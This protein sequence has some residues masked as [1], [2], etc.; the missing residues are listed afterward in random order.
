VTY[1]RFAK[2][3]NYI[4]QRFRAV[5]PEG[6]PAFAGVYCNKVVARVWYSIRRL[7]NRVKFAS[8]LL[9]EKNRFSLNE[10]QPRELQGARAQFEDS[11]VG[12][13]I[14]SS[15]TEFEEFRTPWSGW[16]HCPEADLDYFS[17]HL[18][19]AP[20]V[21]RPHVMVIYRGGRADCMLKETARS[22]SIEPADRPHPAAK[23]ACRRPLRH[24]LAA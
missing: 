6:F 5:S 9:I 3:T 14:L 8:I 12:L 13:R 11:H 18:K 23:P 10:E 7:A 19:H 24:Y 22:C 4:P 2:Q 17:I 21:V 15:V 20:G 1:R 16:T